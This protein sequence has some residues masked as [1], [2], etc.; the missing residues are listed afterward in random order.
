MSIRQVHL[1]IDRAGYREVNINIRLGWDILEIDGGVVFV[2]RFGKVE[3]ELVV[4]CEIIEAA[5]VDWVS[6]V[7]VLG[8]ALLTVVPGDALGRAE[9][10][11]GPVVTGG[12]LAVAFTRLT[13]SPV[14]WVA[15]ETLGTLL[16]V[17]P[18]G[19]M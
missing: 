2:F 15:K 16:A 6:K 1:G 10:V 19:V 17:I 4:D 3:C 13:L 14:H 8:V 18:S 9:A 11:A 12:A 7:V 5:G